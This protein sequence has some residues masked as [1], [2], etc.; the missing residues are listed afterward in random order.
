MAK[1]MGRLKLAWI[2]GAV[3]VSVVIGGGPV[4][5]RSVPCAANGECIGTKKA[6]T[7]Q[8][9]GNNVLD[10]KAGNDKLFSG[11][12]SDVL[13]GPGNDSLTAVGAIESDGNSGGYNNLNGGP[14]NDRINAPA[15]FGYNDITGDSGNDV[16]NAK[17]GAPDTIDC[18]SGKDKVSFDAA[19]DTIANCEVQGS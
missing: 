2:V 19:L 7:I 13:G 8:G 3:A 14:G 17:N 10:G 16:I 15:G 4:L 11:G 12:G 6:D 18:G 5:A 1:A 9:P